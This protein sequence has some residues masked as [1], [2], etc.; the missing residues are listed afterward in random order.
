MNND[1][2]EKGWPYFGRGCFAVGNSKFGRDP[3]VWRRIFAW[4]RL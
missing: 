1:N 4:W 3:L 2:M